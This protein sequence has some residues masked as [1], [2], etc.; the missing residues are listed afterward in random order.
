MQNINNN[1]SVSSPIALPSSHIHRT[2]SEIQLFEDTAAAEWHDL[3]MFHRIV[4]GIHKKH[5]NMRQ[6]ET[7]QHLA[8]RDYEKKTKKSYENIVR[9]HCKDLNN[10]CCDEND[11]FIG[12]DN[13]SPC[14]PKSAYTR[15]HEY[16]H[17]FGSYSSS[18]SFD[19]SRTSVIEPQDEGHMHSVRLDFHTNIEAEEMFSLDL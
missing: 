1:E 11:Y 6:N 14:D 16:I 9:Y 4:N 19:V 13:T 8:Q 15:N 18:G 17:S 10:D 3:S 2:Q 12:Y 7:C 5:Q